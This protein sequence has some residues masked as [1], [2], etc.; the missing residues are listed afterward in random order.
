MYLGMPCDFEQFV[1]DNITVASDVLRGCLHD[2]G[3][4]GTF[5]GD[6]CLES[7]SLIMGEADIVSENG[8]L[9]EIKCSTSTRA[10]DMRDSGNCKYLL[11]V[12]AYVA[13]ARH[14]TIPL[15]L[16]M[17]CIVNPLTGAWERY[18]LKTWSENDST[19]F[20]LCLEELRL[21]C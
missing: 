19:E 16:E 3:A 15:I 2:T 4:T 8:V 21:R 6:V 9:L 12:L 7:A 13:L 11:Q 1:I 10:I 18:D 5:K 14:G 17:A 20:M